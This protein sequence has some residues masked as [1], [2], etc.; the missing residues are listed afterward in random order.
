MLRRAK[1]SKIEVVAPEEK[2]EED[3]DEGGEEEEEEEE[4]GDEGE[5]EGGGEDDEDGE[6]EEEVE[7]EEET[8]QCINIT[9]YQIAAVTLLAGGKVLFV[10]EKCVKF[11]IQQ[12]DT[13]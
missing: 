12:E 4:E 8:C 7:G 3:D 9:A 11:L 5:G 1:H 6:E 2:E 13:L 10:V